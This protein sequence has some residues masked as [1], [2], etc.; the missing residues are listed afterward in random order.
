MSKDKKDDKRVG[1]P[2]RKIGNHNWQS[3]VVTKKLYACEICSEKIE[4]GA[5]TRYRVREDNIVVHAHVECVK[6]GKG[7]VASEMRDAIKAVREESCV[8]CK[9]RAGCQ[10]D[11]AIV[12]EGIEQIG[13]V[14]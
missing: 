8:G 14:G 10:A 2:D 6:K 9:D 1:Q 4:V 13:Q 11:C 12:L 5:S 3:V 7:K